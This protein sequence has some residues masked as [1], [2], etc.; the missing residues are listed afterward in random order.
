M[1][2]FR[3]IRFG[4]VERWQ[5]SVYFDYCANSTINASRVSDSGP[6]NTVVVN[7]TKPGPICWQ[8]GA[9]T[10]GFGDRQDEQCLF[11]DVYRPAAAAAAAATAADGAGADASVG[12]SSTSDSASTTGASSASLVPVV[13]WLHGGSLVLGSTTMFPGIDYL[14]SSTNMLFVVPNYRVAAHGF[15]ALPSLARSAINGKGH[16]VT[17]IDELSRH[18]KDIFDATKQLRRNKRSF[19]NIY[20]GYKGPRLEDHFMQWFVDEPQDTFGSVVPVRISTVNI[21]HCL[22]PSCI[23]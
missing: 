17:D 7:A 6:A 9:L 18:R 20:Q 1:A 11:L 10:R 12:A 16:F 19:D 4:S 21:A 8:I 13:L 23:P 2:V 15:L 5:P 22:D 14:A 3:G